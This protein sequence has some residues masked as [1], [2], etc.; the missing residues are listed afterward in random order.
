MILQAFAI[1]DL[2]CCDILKFAVEKLFTK[3]LVFRV[4]DVIIIHVTF[5]RRVSG[6]VRALLRSFVKF[7]LC[8][9]SKLLMKKNSPNCHQ[10]KV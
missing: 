3:I 8:L 6:E 1:V 5:A 7:P 9:L 10:I 2:G 4:Y